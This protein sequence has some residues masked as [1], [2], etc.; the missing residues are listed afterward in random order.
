MVGDTALGLRLSANYRIERQDNAEGGSGWVVTIVRYRYSLETLE[1]REIVAWHLHS[2]TPYSTSHPHLHLGPGAEIGREELH[3]A[4]LPTGI[5][6][7]ADI[8]RSA[9]TD[10]HAEP[11]RDDWQAILDAA[12]TLVTDS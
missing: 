6:T 9:I 1:E 11:R 5:V 2:G 7:V 3:R 10:F 8:V 12:M 4:H